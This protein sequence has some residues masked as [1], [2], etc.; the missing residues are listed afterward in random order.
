MYGFES[1][2]VI[3][4][5][6]D[7]GRDQ[8]FIEGQVFNAFCFLVLLILFLSFYEMKMTFFAVLGV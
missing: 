7:Q 5:F 2:S 4:I 8:Y 1:R 6:A 3:R